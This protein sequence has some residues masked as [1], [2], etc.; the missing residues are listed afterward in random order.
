MPKNTMF[1]FISIPRNTKE[2]CAMPE[3]HMKNPFARAALTVLVLCQ[4]SFSLDD[5][6][7]MLNLLSGPS[8]LSSADISLLQ[9][10]LD[11]REYIPYSFFANATPENGYEPSLP[12]VISV[13]D[14][15]FSYKMP[16]YVTLYVQSSGAETPRMIQL[17][18]KESTGE[19]FLWEQKLLDPI[20]EPYCC[21]PYK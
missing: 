13:R 3:Y 1:S 4:Y 11:G 16:G 12:F 2:L 21:D 14:T 18:K 17:R 7:E 10:S 15:T 19:W 6:V 9:K 20:Q 5:T 8:T